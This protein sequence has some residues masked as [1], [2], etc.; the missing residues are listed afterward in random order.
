MIKWKRELF[1][2]RICFR[3]TRMHEKKIREKLE[4]R[5]Q[6]KIRENLQMISHQLLQ[7]PWNRDM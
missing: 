1:I 3:R 6:K 7:A 5:N 2:R 4:R